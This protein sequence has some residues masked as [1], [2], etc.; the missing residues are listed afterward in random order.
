MWSEKK[1]YAEGLVAMVLRVWQ[2][3]KEDVDCVSREDIRWMECLSARAV[4]ST[5][6]GEYSVASH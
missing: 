5:S 6:S 4:V 3:L 2:L 1:F